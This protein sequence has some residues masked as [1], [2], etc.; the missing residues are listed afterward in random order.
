MYEPHRSKTGRTTNLALCI[1]A[2]VFLLFLAAGI[3]VVYFLLF[4]PK[5]PKIA[6]DAVQ[7]PTFSVANGTVD[8][9]F[10]QYVTV[11]NP[12]RDAFTHYDSSLQLAYSDAPV[13]FIFILHHSHGATKEGGSTKNSKETNIK[14]GD[15][16][17]EGPNK[18][19]IGGSGK[20]DGDK[21]PSR[22]RNAISNDTEEVHSSKENIEGR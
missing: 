10:Y 16:P 20:Y 5:D 18:A 4:K 6:V 14:I 17:K 2:T 19:T 21:E 13:G 9:T 12:N 3:V 22:N 8:F 7:F 11:F 1:M 15:G